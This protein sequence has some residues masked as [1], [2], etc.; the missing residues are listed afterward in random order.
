[1]LRRLCQPK[2]SHADAG[3][4]I[5]KLEFLIAVAREQNFRR[6][7]EACGVAQPT[8]SAGIKS[9]EEQLGVQLVRR[10]SR[11]QGMT[12]EGERVLDWAQRLVGDARAMR[13]EVRSFRHG[14]SGSLRLAVIPTALPY[15]PTLTQPYGAL[16]PGV[17]FTILSRSSDDILSQ[18]EGLRVDAGLTYLGNETLGRLRAL[19]LYVER[20]RLVTTAGSALARRK[21]L[22]WA[23]V[24]ALP[25]CLLPPE[26]QNRRILDRLLHPSSAETH[27]CV[28]EADSTLA[29]LAH[30][31]VGGVSTIVSEQVALLLTGSGTFRT[32]PIHGDAAFTVGLVVP[33]RQPMSPALRT[34]IK[35]AE[36]VSKA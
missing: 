2:G 7:A 29:L 32:I 33:D 25:L 16:H 10:S 14:L 22:S 35:V 9:L 11:F 21:T 23:E 20:Y 4:M 24:A 19:P 28:L 5:E 1:M 13:Q 31:R 8:L 6:A 18:F 15:T 30:V 26:M 3:A 27:S 36:Q 34:L 17:R 12:P